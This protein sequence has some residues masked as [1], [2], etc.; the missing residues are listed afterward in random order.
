MDYGQ[1]DIVKS[2]DHPKKEEFNLCAVL[3]A[4]SDPLRLAFIRKIWEE[5]E[6]RCSS[7]TEPKAKST[8][9]HHF[10]VLRESGLIMTTVRGTEFGLS[11]RKDELDERFPGLMDSVLAS[12]GKSGIDRSCPGRK[13]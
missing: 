12:A 5:G 6:C 3:D 13:R 10:K 9:S 8:R 7:F 2:F 4:L 11:L 1:G